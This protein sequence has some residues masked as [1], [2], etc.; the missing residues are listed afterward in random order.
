MQGA[1]A[2]DNFELV[3]AAAD[4]G[5]QPLAAFV[6]RA[7]R[8]GKAKALTEQRRSMNLTNSLSSDVFG[9]VAEGRGSEFVKNVPRGDVDFVGPDAR[10]PRLRGLDPQ[11]VDVSIDGVKLASADGWQSTGAGARSFSFD[12]VS[13]SAPLLWLPTA[14]SRHTFLQLRPSLR[15]CSR[16]HR[17]QRPH[18]RSSNPSSRK[19]S[20]IRAPTPKSDFGRDRKKQSQHCAPTLNEWG[21]F[22]ILKNAGSLTPS[23][24]EVCLRPSFS[25]R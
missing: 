5:V 2:Q 15:Q 4:A 7:E 13:V 24:P 17:G 6:V 19:C 3:P 10:G 1:T 14:Q 16:A 8:E 12:Q 21:F 23:G 18:R 20:F 22:G 25:P 9:D 11:H